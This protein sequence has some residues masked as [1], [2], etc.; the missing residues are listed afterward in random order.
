MSQEIADEQKDIGLA[1]TENDEK[2]GELDAAIKEMEQVELETNHYFADGTYTR[3]LMIP[4]GTVLTGKI[5][6]Y[7]CINILVKGKIKVVTSEDEYDIE[8]PYTFVSGPGVRKAGYVI[9]DAIWINVHPW[10]GNMNLEQIEQQVVVPSN[11][12]LEQDTRE[13]LWLG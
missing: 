10:D 7:S 5:H 13:A 6:R 2:I 9:E 4:A 1:S 12:K 3:E 11:D 8:A